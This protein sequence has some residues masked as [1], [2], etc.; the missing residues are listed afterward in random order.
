MQGE[1]EGHNWPPVS[2]AFPEVRSPRLRERQL[3]QLSS[4]SQHERL[5]RTRIN[6]PLQ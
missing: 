6:H 1:N 5:R 3:D 4:T 2:L